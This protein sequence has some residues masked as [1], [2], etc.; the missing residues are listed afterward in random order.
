MPAAAEPA[1]SSVRLDIPPEPDTRRIASPPSFA[2][3]ASFA[4]RGSQQIPA[5]YA[6]QYVL[7][8]RFI[9]SNNEIARFRAIVRCCAPCQ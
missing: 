8:A 3:R 4:L 7:K 6:S 2:L 5:C 1:F 9:R